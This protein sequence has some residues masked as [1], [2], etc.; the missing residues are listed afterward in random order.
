ME[1]LLLVPALVVLWR[2]VK[3]NR[4]RRRY[5]PG[6]RRHWLLGNLLDMPSVEPW[7]RF[8]EW[9]Q[10]YGDITYLNVLGR[11]IVVLNTLSACA[12]L[13]ERRGAQWSGRPVGYMHELMGMGNFMIMQQE[14]ASWRLQRRLIHRFFGPR[15]VGR[16]AA[17]QARHAALFVLQLREDGVDWRARLR[18]TVSKSAFAV[19]YGLPPETYSADFIRTGDTILREWFAAVVP[20]NYLVDVV[21]ALRFIPTWTPGAGFKRHA[22]SVAKIVRHYVSWYFDEAKNAVERG[23]ALPSFVT[24]CLQERSGAKM[25]ATHTF[26][27]WTASSLYLGKTLQNG[28]RV[29]RSKCIHQRRSIRRTKPW[30]SS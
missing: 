7:L 22:R 15:D 12:E 28:R 24:S 1:L 25:E 29:L 16:H 10:E 6:P 13:L 23:D 30:L 17:V 5:P 11:H 18:L 26:I 9:A 14:T 3:L 8:S 21:P 27:Q 19:M 2:A 20:G 4:Q